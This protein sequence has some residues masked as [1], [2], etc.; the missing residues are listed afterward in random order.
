MAT[1][2]KIEI[3]NTNVEI[4]HLQ[5]RIAVREEEIAALPKGD[6]AK[7]NAGQIATLKSEI[8]QTNSSIK[9]LQARI[10]PSAEPVKA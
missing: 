3:A 1:P 7:E 6:G 4:A 5:L 8:E 9:Q 2:S 10:A